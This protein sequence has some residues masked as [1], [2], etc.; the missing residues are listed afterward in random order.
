MHTGN[1]RIHYT[2]VLWYFWVGHD[3]VVACAMHLTAVSVA[4]KPKRH[5]FVAFKNAFLKD[6]DPVDSKTNTFD[7][8]CIRE[9]DFTA[10]QSRYYP[11]CLPRNSI[12]PY[13]AAL[14]VGLLLD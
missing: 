1:K 2:R 13:L 5:Q 6:A 10:S 3:Y 12:R 8:I 7:K 11:I 9:L 4:R 14:G